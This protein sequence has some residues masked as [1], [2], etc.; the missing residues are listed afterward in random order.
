M[1]ARHELVGDVDIV[2][3]SGRLNLDACETFKE[4]CLTQFTGK[5]IVICMEGLSFVGSTGITIFLDTMKELRTKIEQP[6]KFCNVSSE[7]S[8]IFSANL[9][10]IYE[11]YENVEMAIKSFQHVYAS[12]FES[13]MWANTAPQQSPEMHTVPAG[14]TA[15]PVF[16]IQSTLAPAQQASVETEEVSVAP[17][18]PKNIDDQNG[19]Q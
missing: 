15:Q 19:N 13:D 12:V 2:Y 7:Y 10:G 18:A 14:A 5:K 4:V 6:V 11:I 8:K 9:I 16:G 17:E 3:L 1:Q